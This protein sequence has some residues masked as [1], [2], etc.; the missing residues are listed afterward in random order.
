[1]GLNEDYD[2]DS[3]YEDGIMGDLPGET[4]EPEDEYDDEL[5]EFDIPN[6]A[7]SALING[8]E[9]GLT[10]EEQE[11]LNAFVD[12]VASKYG[13]ANFMLPD[14]NEID[15]GFL[16][17][18]DIDNLG[19]DCS[20][21][22][23]RPTSN[24]DENAPEGYIPYKED[25]SDIDE[26]IKRFMDHNNITDMN[27]GIKDYMALCLWKCDEATSDDNQEGEA[28]WMQRYNAAKDKLSGMMDEAGFQ[29]EP[30]FQTPAVGGDGVLENEEED[31]DGMDIGLD[32]AAISHLSD[33]QEEYPELRGR[34]NFIKALIMDMGCKV[35]TPTEKLDALYDKYNS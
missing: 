30:N 21:L 24:M 13:N 32:V 17:S 4:Q 33:I 25:Q 28:V 19:G 2:I 7:I 11:K 29:G 35:K 9:S 22:L 3:Q 34:I 26:K 15:L 31:D 14:E 20:R 27:Q 12:D 16:R 23:I 5:I 6:W 10:D 1:M 18:N 8:D